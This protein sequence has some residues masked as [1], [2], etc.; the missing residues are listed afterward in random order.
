MRPYLVL[1]LL[2]AACA[3][4]V[5]DGTPLP[6]FPTFPREPAGVSERIYLAAGPPLGR[7]TLQGRCLGIARRGPGLTTVAWPY[8]ASLGR[9][10]RGLFVT[11]S[12]S[13][14]KLRLGDWVSFGSSPT[15]GDTAH[16]MTLSQPIPAECR[17]SMIAIDPGFVKRRRP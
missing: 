17:S 5:P 10:R 9:D 11:D 13:G 15:D 2:A 3:T 16:G 8:T 4:P 1:P 6:P 12:E 14:A 7:L